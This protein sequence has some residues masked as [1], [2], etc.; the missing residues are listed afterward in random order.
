MARTK[1]TYEG[2]YVPDSARAEGKNQVAWNSVVV[3]GAQE[4]RII[5]HVQTLREFEI[6][7]NDM[8]RA[9]ERASARQIFNLGE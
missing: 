9:K 7:L 5:R 8:R 1:E 3:D 2:K 4:G 6:M